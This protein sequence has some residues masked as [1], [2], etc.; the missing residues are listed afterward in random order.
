[1]DKG[2]LLIISGPS[3]SGKGTVAKHLLAA[4]GFALSISMTTRQPR[5]GESHGIDYFFCTK[6][7]FMQVRDSDGLLEHATFSGHYYGTPDS[8]V[9]QMVDEGK[10]VVLEIDV[11]GALQVKEKYSN[12]VL[13]FLMPPDA[14]ELARRLNERAS[15]D[16]AE[17]DRRL[18]RAKEE[19][20]LI[21]KYDY[22]VIN[23]DLQQAVSEIKLIAAA[24]YLRTKRRN[25]DTQSFFN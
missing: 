5:P 21:S 9:R 16:S 22:L 10:T 17:I 2:M 12:A 8:Y 1:M 19:I 7:E 6:D 18:K 11:E 24:E 15:E 13:I 23:D 25:I 3:G 20:A 14:N 4:D